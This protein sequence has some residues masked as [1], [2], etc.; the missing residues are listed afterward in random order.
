VDGYSTWEVEVWIIIR[1][2]EVFGGQSYHFGDN[3]KGSYCLSYYVA[4]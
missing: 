2:D 3:L 1:N 4:S